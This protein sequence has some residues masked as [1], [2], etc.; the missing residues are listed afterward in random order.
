M[1]LLHTLRTPRV[2]DIAL[3]D[4]ILS[5]IGVEILFSYFGYAKYTGVFLT[6][7]I[8]ILFHYIFNINTELNYKLGISD[9][10]E[11]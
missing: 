4:L 2:F 9:K 6:L 10:P 1:S 8:A 7:P 11:R 5:I 3:F